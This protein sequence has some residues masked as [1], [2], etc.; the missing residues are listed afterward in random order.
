MHSLGLGDGDGEGEG[1]VKDGLGG[2]GAACSSLKESVDRVVPV[3]ALLMQKVV[4]HGQDYAQ[5]N[6]RTKHIGRGNSPH[7]KSGKEDAL[8]QKSHE[9]PPP[10]SCKTEGASRDLDGYWRHLAP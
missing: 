7:I 6:K 4:S 10:Q 2:G 5:E 8:A 1:A 3:R 9:S